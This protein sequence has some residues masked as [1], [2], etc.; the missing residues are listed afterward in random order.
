VGPFADAFAGQAEGVLIDEDLSPTT[1]VD[2]VLPRG[3][4]LTLELCGELQRLAP[5]GL[6]NPQV[7]LLAPACEVAELATVGE[8][9]HLRFR[10]LRDGLDEGS[11]IA[12][13][14]GKHLDRLRRVGHYDVAFRLEENHWN[15]TVAPQLVVRRVFDAD[16][17]FEEVYAWLRT[18]W[19]AKP[20]DALAQAIFDELEVEVG[21]PRRH[22]L[23]SETFRAL[24]AAPAL[25]EA[26]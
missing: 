13:G 1:V 21:G 4:K 20:R 3:T 8:G 26:A 9:K 2:A 17:R 23:E 12:F 19:N 7:T 15:G 10:V 6:G 18:Q 24:L 5:F 11:A 22:P 25:L 14:Q 16:S